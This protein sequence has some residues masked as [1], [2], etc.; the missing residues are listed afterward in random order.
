MNKQS[1]LPIFRKG[2]YIILC[3]CWM[4][5][6]ANTIVNVESAQQLVKVTLDLQDVEI[7]N[8]LEKIK[9]QTSFDFVYNARE[10]NDKLKVSVKI[11][12]VDIQTALKAFLSDLNIDF[13]I[14]DKIVI[15]QKK[16]DNQQIK[17]N[18]Y[19]LSGIVVDSK[20]NPLP[21]VSV[22]LKGTTLGVATDL[23]G[24]F[25]FRIPQ[26]ASVPVLLFSFIGMETQEYK[27]VNP[28][29]EVRI[30]MEEGAEALDEVVVTGMETIR[31]EHMTGSATVVT[32]KDLKMQGITSIDRI[33]EGM[34]GR[35]K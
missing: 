33:L 5:L 19:T 8:V 26:S 11:L 35:F 22:I 29:K 12:D 30:I 28:N 7:R 23:S 27:V 32:A 2:L 6:S 18:Y 25:T 14:K 24:H 21:G 3:I 34:G 9:E 15:L 31:K 4:D 1:I 16:Q 10:I 17:E 13:V 20:N